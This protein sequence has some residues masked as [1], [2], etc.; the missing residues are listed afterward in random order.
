MTDEDYEERATFIRWNW[1]FVALMMLI[2]FLI[3][4]AI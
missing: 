1:W 4:L 2:G 3:G